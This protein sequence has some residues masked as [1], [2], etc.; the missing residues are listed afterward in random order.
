MAKEWSSTKMDKFS[1]DLSNKTKESSV[2][3]HSQTGPITK[4][5]SETIWP[6]VTVNFTG[7]TESNTQGNGK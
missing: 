7:R 6:T 1:R 2:K 3:I 5:L 4:A